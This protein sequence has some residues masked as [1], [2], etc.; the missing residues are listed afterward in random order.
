MYNNKNNES[1][2]RDLRLANE[3]KKGSKAAYAELF[4]NYKQCIYNKIYCMVQHSQLAEDLLMDIF[5]KVSDNINAFNPKIAS[6]SAWINSI[7]KNRV[8]DH[9]K[10]SQTKKNISLCSSDTIFRKV[11]R[12]RETSNKYAEIELSQHYLKLRKAIDTKISC[13]KMNQALKMRFLSELSYKEISMAMHEKENTVKSY[14]HRAKKI[15]KK[16]IKDFR[17]DD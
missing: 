11:S 13:K 17:L 10:S 16:K 15:L 6:F 7:A 4:I 2:L 14:I 12:I 9:F 5:V 3:F 8:Y 1:H